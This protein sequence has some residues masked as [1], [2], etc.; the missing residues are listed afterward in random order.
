[1]RV[2]VA[3]LETKVIICNSCPFQHCYYYVISSSKLLDCVHSIKFSAKMPDRFVKPRDLLVK[4]LRIVWFFDVRKVLDL[5]RFRQ[6]INIWIW[7]PPKLVKRVQFQE[8]WVIFY[9]FTFFLKI[10]EPI[11]R[12]TSIINNS[13]KYITTTYSNGS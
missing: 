4:Q 5:S 3:T 10:L 2:D 12:S 11:L 7:I 13:V 6:K 8:E 1:M 9:N